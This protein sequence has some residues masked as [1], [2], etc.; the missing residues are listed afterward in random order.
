M[1]VLSKEAW[2][3]WEE[4]GYVVVHNAVPQENLDA[5]VDVIWE[6]LEMGRP[7][8]YAPAASGVDRVG[9]QAAGRGFV[10]IL[11]LMKASSLSRPF[12]SRTTICANSV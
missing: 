4:N 2:A 5:M 9:A 10:L 8:A 7:G 1:P 6:F 11:N 12:P 3:F